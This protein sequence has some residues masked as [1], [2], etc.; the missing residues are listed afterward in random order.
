ALTDSNRREGAPPTGRADSKVR[1]PTGERSTL[2]LP[3][4]IPELAIPLPL[5]DQLVAEKTAEPRYIPLGRGVGGEDLEAFAGGDVAH[6]VVQ[7]HHRLRAHQAA[8]V[9]L[10]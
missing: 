4:H 1:S 8:G 6:G 5:L 7:Q 10:G 9:E 2:S 3:Y